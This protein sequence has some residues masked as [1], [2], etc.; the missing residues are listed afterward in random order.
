MAN[1]IGNK[2]ALKLKTPELRKEAFRQYCEHIAGG[3]QKKSWYFVHPDITCCWAT[4]EK[5]I[6][7]FSEEFDLEH[8]A[9]AQAKSM[10]FWETI[11]YDA[12]KGAAKDCSPASLQMIFRN[13]FGW[14]KNSAHDEDTNTTV[15]VQH[16]QHQILQ[17]MA[18]MQETAKSTAITIE[19]QGTPS[20]NED[21][22]ETTHLP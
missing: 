15:A 22:E 8:I 2:S 13:K 20:R 1:L 9:V 6:L 19:V 10:K 12:A 7:D 17:Q 5:T 14:D 11:L 18:E 16:N 21:T 3:W 4:I